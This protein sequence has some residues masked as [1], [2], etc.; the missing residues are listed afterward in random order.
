VLAEVV[1]SCVQTGNYLI[2]SLDTKLS[3]KLNKIA[4]GYV[5]RILLG[6]TRWAY[7]AHW[8]NEQLIKTLRPS[9]KGRDDFV[10]LDKNGRILLKWISSNKIRECEMDLSGSK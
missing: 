9:L 6:E 10:C 4:D 5:T 3:R 7:I 8:R 2:I 1:T